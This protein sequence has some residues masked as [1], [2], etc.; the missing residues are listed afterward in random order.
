MKNE[1]EVGEGGAPSPSS[2]PSSP[3]SY[4]PPSPSTSSP[5][6]LLPSFHFS[7]FFSSCPLLRAK[8]AKNAFLEL[9][10]SFRG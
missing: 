7:S 3:S 10:M 1:E 9:I 5:L 2:P 6:L 4:P 8:L